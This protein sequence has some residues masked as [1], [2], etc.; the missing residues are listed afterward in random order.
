MLWRLLEPICTRIQA[1]ASANGQYR[2][3]I[4]W[5]NYNLWENRWNEA[6]LGDTYSAQQ[7]WIL[8]HL[9]MFYQLKKFEIPSALNLLITT[10]IIQTGELNYS[11]TILD[12]GTRWSWAV[13]F[14]RK[15]QYRLY[16]VVSHSVFGSCGEEKT[17]LPLTRIK[18]WFL[19]RPA[20]SRSFF[21]TCLP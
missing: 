16:K 7:C 21:V 8:D 17:S 6:D 12:L 9:T 15:T 19:G 20:R 11:S 18:P 1:L 2:I 13:K 14:T 10:Q 3:E 4:W 5:V